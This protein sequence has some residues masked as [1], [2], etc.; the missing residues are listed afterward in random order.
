[1]KFFSIVMMC[2]LTSCNAFYAHKD[3]LKP[4]AHDMTD[5]AIDDAA[6]YMHEDEKKIDSTS[7]Q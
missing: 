7:T 6:A 1:M 2:L 4:I 5:E 3:D